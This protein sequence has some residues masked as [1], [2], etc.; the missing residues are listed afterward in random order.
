MPPFDP[1]ILLG[2]IFSIVVLLIIGG[3][4]VSFPLFRRLGR[5]MDEWF[6]SRQHE[7]LREQDLREVE[8]GLSEFRTRLEAME[9]RLELLAERQ[10]FTESLLQSGDVRPDGLPMGP[11]EDRPGGG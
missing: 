1:V 5:L 7:R 2:M 11:E 8:D 9:D 6:V 4:I 10:E 3:F